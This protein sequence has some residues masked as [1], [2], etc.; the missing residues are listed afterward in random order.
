MYRFKKLPDFGLVHQRCQR[1]VRSGRFGVTT[2]EELEGQ[3]W[4][5]V[6]VG[7]ISFRSATRVHR[8]RTRQIFFIRIHHKDGISFDGQSMA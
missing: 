1:T 7:V 6:Q 4:V 8:H 3:V 5:G 2:G